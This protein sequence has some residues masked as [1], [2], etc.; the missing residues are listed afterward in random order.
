MHCMLYVHYRGMQ[1]PLRN[2]LMPHIHACALAFSPTT[3][4]PTQGHCNTG[5]VERLE[6]LLT[7]RSVSATE[8]YTGIS[9]SSPGYAG[10][11]LSSLFRLKQLWHS[12]FSCKNCTCMCYVH[13]RGMQGRFACMHMPHHTCLRF[14]IFIS[15]TACLGVA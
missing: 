3:P 15:S 1:C 2:M 8:R 4:Q 12:Q 13:Y 14:S 11:C 5:S 6:L 9:G 7:R 10:P